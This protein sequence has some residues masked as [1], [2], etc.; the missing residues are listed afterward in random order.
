M[1]TVWGIAEL[2]YEAHYGSFLGEVLEKQETKEKDFICSFS[3]VG[4]SV[5]G[6]CFEMKSVCVLE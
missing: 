2:S 5:N 6:R 1:S 4:Q 3:V